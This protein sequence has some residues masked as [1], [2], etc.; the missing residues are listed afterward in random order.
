MNED[1]LPDATETRR[2]VALVIMGVSGSGKSLVGERLAERLGWTLT[3]GDR[4]HPPEN[5]EK[6]RRG[7]ALTD[8]DRAPWLDRIAELLVGWAA[9]GRSGLVTCSALKRAYRQ[10]LIAA[11]S[12][13][14]FVYL[15]GSAALIA[16]RVNARH[17]EYMPASL[18]KS[19]FDTLEE[20]LP[21]EPVITIDASEAPEAEVGAIVAALGL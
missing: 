1:T 14:R 21:G 13:L 18:L 5:V 16:A 19:Q 12:D 3:E 6:M 8:Q 4:L 9:E 20:P 10:R 7:I 17:H 11:R 15:K 2:P